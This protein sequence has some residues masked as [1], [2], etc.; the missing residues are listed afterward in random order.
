MA[1]LAAMKISMTDI[2]TASCHAES[3]SSQ[4]IGKWNTAEPMAP[5]HSTF[6][7]PM[8][9]DSLPQKGRAAMN[10]MLATTPAHRASPRSIFRAVVA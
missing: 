6:L 2:D 9:S 10:T 8:R 4:V 5:A 3:F 1:A 7:R